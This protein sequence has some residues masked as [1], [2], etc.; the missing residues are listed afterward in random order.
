MPAPFVIIRKLSVC[1]DF[2]TRRPVVL[3]TEGHVVLYQRP[4]VEGRAQEEGGSNLGY[5]K[6]K[7]VNENICNVKYAFIL[8]GSIKENVTKI[9]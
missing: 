6:T 1:V 2:S 5:H 9:L 3:L 7:N 4:G 8:R